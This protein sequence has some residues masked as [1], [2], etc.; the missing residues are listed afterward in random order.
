MGW[1]RRREKK[2]KQFKT[3]RGMLVVHVVVKLGREGN[4]RGAVERRKPAVPSEKERIAQDGHSQRL[5]AVKAR[6]QQPEQHEKNEAKRTNLLLRVQEVDQAVVFLKEAGTGSL[7]EVSAQNHGRV[8][9]R[10]QNHLGNA[11]SQAIRLNRKKLEDTARLLCFSPRP[12]CGG[13]WQWTC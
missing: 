8:G 1:V 11:L 2:G 3:N 6:P 13:D 12:G 7:V 10:R 9:H 5:R 4:G